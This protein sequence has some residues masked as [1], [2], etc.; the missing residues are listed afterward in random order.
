MADAPSTG[1]EAP[2]VGA[3]GGAG[4]EDISAPEASNAWWQFSSKDDAEK[5]ANDLITKRLSRHKKS[6]V[7]PIEQERDTLRAEVER[8]KPLEDATKTD[9]E[10]W[11]SEKKTLLDEVTSLRAFK[12]EQ[13][14]REMVRSIAEE[15]GLPAKFI[16]RVRG[17]DE[18]SVREDITELLN[19]LSEGG[20][21]PGKKVPASKAPKESENGGKKSL[22]SGGGGSDEQSDDDLIKEILG[23]VAKD[24]ANGGLMTRR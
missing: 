3:D 10:R 1:P 22:S 18:D 23:Q 14:H 2:E 16:P 21:T 24:R 6:V 11:E 12:A 9:A 20:S 17:D 13:S 4:S 7:D 5:W 15:L 19:V 8:L